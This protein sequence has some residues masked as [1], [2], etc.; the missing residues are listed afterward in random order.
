MN[1]LDPTAHRACDEVHQANALRMRFLSWVAMDREDTTVLVMVLLACFLIGSA[2][3]WIATHPDDLRTSTV[4]D[5]TLA[6]PVLFDFHGTSV[7]EGSAHP[8]DV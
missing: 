7:G 5:Q 2:T 6:H 3:A 8:G 4:E 1:L